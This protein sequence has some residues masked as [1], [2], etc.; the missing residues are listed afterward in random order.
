M[1][2]LIRLIWI[3]AISFSVTAGLGMMVL[4]V[5]RVFLPG[6][7]GAGAKK[8]A[9]MIGMPLLLIGIFVAVWAVG[10]GKLPGTKKQ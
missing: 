4:A 7:D 6:L 8:L 3:A 1:R 5:T 9:D 10:Q 2:A